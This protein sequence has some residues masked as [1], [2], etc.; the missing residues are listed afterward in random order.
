VSA[1]DPT[2]AGGISCRDSTRLVS[3]S[4]D[5]P[6]SGDEAARLATHVELCPH[7]RIAA[8]QFAELFARVDLLLARTIGDGD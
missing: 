3:E 8:R 7:C 2:R 4:R 5:R 6:L 1:F